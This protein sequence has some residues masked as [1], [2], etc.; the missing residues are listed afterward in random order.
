MTS[1]KCFW[2]NAKTS[3]SLFLAVGGFWGVYRG[4]WVVQFLSAGGRWVN[5]HGPGRTALRPIDSRE[6]PPDCAATATW[7]SRWTSHPHEDALF[8]LHEPSDQRERQSAVPVPRAVLHTF[9]AGAADAGRRTHRAQHHRACAF[10][11]ERVRAVATSSQPVRS[12]RDPWGPS[13]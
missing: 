8:D 13:I 6:I 7:Q 10:A 12:A 9:A 3:V 2:L 5:P 4:Q 11:C 1:V